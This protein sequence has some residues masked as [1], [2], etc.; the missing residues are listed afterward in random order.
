MRTLLRTLAA[1]AVL[2][3]LLL[4]GT[5]SALAGS[6][7]GNGA[8]P[9]RYDF[10]SEWCFDQGAWVDCTVVDAALFVTATPDGRVIARITFR[11]LT[12]SYDSTGAEIGTVRTVSFDRTVFAEG[13]Q[14]STFSVSHTRA[15]GD[16]GTCVTT[17]LFKV[18]DYEIEMDMY[19]GPGCS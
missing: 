17:Y 10:D 18:V 16:F 2:S 4:G 14:D 7:S 15:V 3:V 1:T 19:T 12:T 9:E 11:Q 8:T 13:G 5:T 6:P